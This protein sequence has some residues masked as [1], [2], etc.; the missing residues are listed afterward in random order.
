MLDLAD[1]FRRAGPAYRER[2]GERMLPSHKRAMQDIEDC[3]TP[4]MGGQLFRCNKCQSKIHSYHS[5][6][7]RHC[8]K[9]QGVSTSAWIQK[10]TRLL[11]PGRYYLARYLYRVAI[12]NRS[13]DTFDRESVTF[14]WQESRTGRIHHTKLH[15]TIENP[16]RYNQAQMIS[17]IESNNGFCRGCARQEALLR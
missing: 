6:K 12:N 8:P 16:Y 1:I 5:C 13:I 7:N 10:M 2:F 3:R 17:R 11:L 14:R 9:C 15:V 4:A